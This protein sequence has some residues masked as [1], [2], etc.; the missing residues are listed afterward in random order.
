M[1]LI[2]SR[3]CSPV[4]KRVS[5]GDHTPEHLYQADVPEHEVSDTGCVI[6]MKLRKACI[7][8][9]VA[10][11]GYDVLVVRVKVRLAHCSAVDFQLG[12]FLALEAFYQQEIAR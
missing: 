7:E 4:T 2:I 6:E 1:C 8:F 3:C 11:D 10:R 9:L 12:Q 5:T